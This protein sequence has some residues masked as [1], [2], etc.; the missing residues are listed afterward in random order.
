MHDRTGL[1]RVDRPHKVTLGW[2]PQPRRDVLAP[3]QVHK[4]DRDDNQGHHRDANECADE[5][6]KEPS[7]E[8]TE[9][10]ARKKAEASP[11]DPPALGPLPAIASVHNDPR[12]A[13]V[14]SLE[15]PG[16]TDR[17]PEYRTS[18][19]ISFIFQALS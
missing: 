9:K 7:Q 13:S 5:P 10:N 19:R 15:R 16:R 14:R 12:I 4:N 11:L 6:G 3:S 18:I 2:G 8:D 17:S 1:N